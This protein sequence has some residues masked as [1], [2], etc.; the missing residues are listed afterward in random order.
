MEEEKAT[1][2]G[3]EKKLGGS[4]LVDSLGFASYRTECRLK[5][6]ELHGPLRCL[7]RRI[8]CRTFFGKAIGGK[9]GE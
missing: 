6:R 2:E 3:E 5:H 8:C 1:D 9:D 7:V 4:Q